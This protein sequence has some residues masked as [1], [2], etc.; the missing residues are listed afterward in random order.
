MRK[1]TVNQSIKDSALK[2]RVLLAQ[3]QSPNHENLT[4]ETLFTLPM[5][6]QG[7]VKLI[8]ALLIAR[9]GRTFG[10]R[11]PLLQH[12][13]DAERYNRSHG[14]PIRVYALHVNEE[15]YKSVQHPDHYSEALLPPHSYESHK[16]TLKP[17]QFELF[18]MIEIRPQRLCMFTNEDSPVVQAYRSFQRAEIDR[19]LQ[20]RSVKDGDAVNSEPDIQRY[21]ADFPTR[22]CK[23]SRTNLVGV[24]E[25]ECHLQIGFNHHWRELEVYR[26]SSE[27]YCREFRDGRKKDFR[28]PEDLLTYVY[29][30]SSRTSADLWADPN[31]MQRTNNEDQLIQFGHNLRV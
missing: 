19:L 12:E 26:L 3:L 14:Y 29:D 22:G 17:E 20:A 23:I 16:Y 6:K 31:T 9:K 24:F 18:G 10:L 11:E 27:K 1:E 5:N 25:S 7:E 15:I 28:S 8:S 30:Q 13:V 2:G 4:P 21:L